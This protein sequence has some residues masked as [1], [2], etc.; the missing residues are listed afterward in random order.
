VSDLD[1]VQPGAGAVGLGEDGDSGELRSRI[2]SNINA[3]NGRVG[4]NSILQPNH[5]RGVMCHDGTALLQEFPG[6]RRM[7]GL[8]RRSV[9]VEYEYY[10]SRKAPISGRFL[11]RVTLACASL[12]SLML[13]A[14]CL[15]ASAPR[16]VPSL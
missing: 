9:A 6:V 3:S 16:F 2:N 7:A 4:G 5:E 12:P 1:R 8:Q 11:A 14:R 10:W 15:S 13:H